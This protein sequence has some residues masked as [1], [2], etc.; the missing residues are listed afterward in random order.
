VVV[1]CGVVWLFVCVGVCVA[2]MM[3]VVRSVSS[4]PFLVW[5]LLAISKG[6]V[7]NVEL[8]LSH[9]KAARERERE[10]ALSVES[11]SKWL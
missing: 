7:C 11:A 3:S 1:W 4:T 6:G 9:H 5:N 10:L 2:W 8:K